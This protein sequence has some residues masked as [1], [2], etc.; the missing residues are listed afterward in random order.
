MFA[1][2]AAALK[3]PR[4]ACIPPRKLRAAF[5]TA[6]SKAGVPDR[7]LKAYMGHSSGDILGGHYRRIDID[8]LRLV[9][10]RIETLLSGIVRKESGNIPQERVANG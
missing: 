5:A 9:S 7:L 1:R 6:A 10:N 8:E 2:A 3:N 4:L